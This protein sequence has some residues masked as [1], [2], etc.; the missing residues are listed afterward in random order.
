MRDPRQGSCPVPCSLLSRQGN[1]TTGAT[2]R[3]DL[4]DPHHLGSRINLLRL[5]HSRRIDQH[6]CLPDLL[7]LYL[8]GLE[9]AIGREKIVRLLV[10]PVVAEG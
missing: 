4:T 7:G 10:H 2:P 3:L 1:Y 5:L 6:I 9:E 8:L